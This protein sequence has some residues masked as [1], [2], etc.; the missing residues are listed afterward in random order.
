MDRLYQIMEYKMTQLQAKAFKLCLIWEELAQK[1]FPKER[2]VP[3][4]PK[5]GDPRESNLFRH[6]YKLLRETRGL[7][8]D[9]QYRF[10]IKAQFD[11]LKNIEVENGCHARVDPG[12]LIGKKAWARWMV[13]LK[14]YKTLQKSENL[15]FKALTEKIKAKLRKTKEFLVHQFKGDP[16]Y[17]NIKQA[18]ESRALTRWITLGKVSGYYAILSPYVKKCIG[19]RSFDEAFSFDLEIYR[20]HITPEIEEFFKEEFGEK[21]E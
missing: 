7:I 11:I 20:P 16:T 4:L 8:L 12:C 9:D 14:K 13:W 19:G 18:F 2:R 1:S 10:Y 21:W 6:C 15:E 3:K 17:E 5:R